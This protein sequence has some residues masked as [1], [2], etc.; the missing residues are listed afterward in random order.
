ME[1]LLVLVG[2]AH[3]AVAGVAVVV[4]VG[5]VDSATVAE[6]GIGGSRI[7]C[8]TLSKLILFSLTEFVDESGKRK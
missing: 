6:A 5:T 1:R 3:V 2:G 7:C 4:N 8:T